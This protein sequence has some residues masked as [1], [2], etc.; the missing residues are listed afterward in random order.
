MLKG[1]KELDTFVI[2]RNVNILKKIIPKLIVENSEITEQPAIIAEQENFYKNLYATKQ[3]I[4][5]AGNRELFFHRDNPYI[6]L[7]NEN[8]AQ[9]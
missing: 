3:T 1:K 9:N 5:E 6:T 7:L 2:W 8:E 4:I